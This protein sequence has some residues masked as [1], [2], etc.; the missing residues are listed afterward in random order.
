[1]RCLAS[2]QAQDPSPL[3]VVIVD[4]STSKYEI[5]DQPS[6]LHVYEPSL[7]G[8]TAAR[9]RAC[10]LADGDILLFVDD[11]VELQPGCLKAISEAAIT[12]PYAIGFQCA[13]A[14]VDR[15]LNVNSFIGAIF[16]RG[17]FNGSHLPG[18]NP[19]KLRRLF[20]CA[21][22]FRKELFA[23]ETFDEN[24]I[25]YGYGE[26]WEFSYRARKY[27][28]FVLVEN[29]SVIH[30]TSPTNRL[31]REQHR[32]VR[33]DSFLYFYSKLGAADYFPNRLWRLWWMLG[34]SIDWF[35]LGMGFPIF[36]IRTGR[37]PLV[38]LIDKPLAPSDS[39]RLARDRSA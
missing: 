7:K 4:Q 21:M 19:R 39:N 35:A 15:R 12:Y 29:A 1:M 3:Q 9:N 37:A 33:W 20:G 38:S 23:H 14:G 16:Q 31:E 5:A 8:L 11:D 2:I 36:G 24:L 10:A 13:I 34:E 25:G 30:H 32:K 27:G 17:F 28:A 6:I 18:D 26:D 22:A